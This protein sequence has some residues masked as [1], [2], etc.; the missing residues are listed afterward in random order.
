MMSREEII[1]TLAQLGNG[2]VLIHHVMRKFGKNGE[3]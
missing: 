3:A 2:L 1:R